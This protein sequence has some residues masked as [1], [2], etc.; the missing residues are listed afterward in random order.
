MKKLQW[1][2]LTDFV[3][4]ACRQNQEPDEQEQQF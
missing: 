2:S 3:A 4:Q 1:L